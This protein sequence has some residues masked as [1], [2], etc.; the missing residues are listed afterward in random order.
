MKERIPGERPDVAV[1]W[2]PGCSMCLKAKEFIEEAGIEFESLNVF[3]REDAQRE[4]VS[5]GLR[6]LPVVRKGDRLMYA[7]SLADI[8]EFLELDTDARNR[9]RLSQG[10]LL[11][12]WDQV[13]DRAR[14]I[15]AGFTDEQ[16]RRAAIIGRD[17]T[18]GQ[19]SSHVFQIPE[20]FLT[21]MDDRDADTREIMR[22][23]R[24]NVVSHEGLD[25]YV[26]KTL[27]QYRDWRNRGGASKIPDV[28]ETFYGRQ[29]SGQVLER[30]VWHS[31]QHARQLDVIAAGMGAEYQIPPELYVGLPLP[32]RL[33]A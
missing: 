20:A 28:I 29:P 18:V 27:A 6:G 25:A 11:D 4:L 12:R 17:R 23:T 3:A 9:A 16:L 14:I 21:S 19:L 8:S 7:Q 5:A 15:I 10:E 31:T 22:S 2:R 30:Y 32:K 24:T 1:Y 13:L 26:D 33:W